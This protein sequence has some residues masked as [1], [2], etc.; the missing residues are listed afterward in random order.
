MA[1]DTHLE[2]QKWGASS[3]VLK[4]WPPFWRPKSR[5]IP[6]KFDVIFDVRFGRRFFTLGV[7]FGPV[8]H[9]FLEAKTEPRGD[10]TAE[11]RKCKNV[12]KVP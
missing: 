6:S 10:P 12:A 1:Q 7:D 2:R 4:F 8:L 3:T 5:K 11:R 9:R